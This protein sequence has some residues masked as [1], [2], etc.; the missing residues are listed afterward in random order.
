MLSN[1]GAYRKEWRPWVHGPRLPAHGSVY[2]SPP[3]ICFGF[4]V[5]HRGQRNSPVHMSLGY[6]QGFFPVK[7]G[8]KSSQLPRDCDTTRRGHRDLQGICESLM[9]VPLSINHLMYRIKSLRCMLLGFVSRT[10]FLERIQTESQG[11]P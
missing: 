2:H 5:R 3:W 11:E 4:T 6:S 8:A 1:E 10:C 9:I 7:S